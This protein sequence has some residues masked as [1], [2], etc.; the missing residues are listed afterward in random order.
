MQIESLA[1][2]FAGVPSAVEREHQASHRIRRARA[3]VGDIVERRVTGG[4][5]I[6]AERRQQVVERL[7]RQAMRADRVGKRGERRQR[8]RL[9]SLDRFQRACE[10]LRALQAA[11]LGLRR[12]R[13]RD[14][15]RFVRTGRPRRPRAASGREPAA[16]RRGSSRSGRRIQGSGDQRTG[17]RCAGA[18]GGGASS[19]VAAQWNSRGMRA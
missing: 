7:H 3:V 15:R 6:L 11:T 5:D 1:R 9:A 12:P 16:T 8:R 17:I 13:R 2:W 10:H 19:A 14:R 4:R 18:F